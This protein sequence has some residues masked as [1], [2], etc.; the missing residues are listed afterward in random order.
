[1]SQEDEIMEQMLA[2]QHS[3]YQTQAPTNNAA[4][5]ASLYKLL[6]GAAGAG[7]GALLALPTGGM[8]IPVGIG[9][10]TTLG[11]AA[12]T[13]AGTPGQME[14]AKQDTKYGKDL[15]AE[16]GD[17]LKQMSALQQK[18]AKLKVRRQML[19]DMQNKQQQMA[20]SFLA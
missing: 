10:G 14:A 7:I 5:N 9:L 11:G 18:L 12:G 15:S 13:L 6:G 16:Q 4:H 1:M 8:S 20:Q 19:N 3:P 2:L 17:R